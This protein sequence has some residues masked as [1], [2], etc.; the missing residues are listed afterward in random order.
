MD[1]RSVVSVVAPCKR[2][3]T[4]AYSLRVDDTWSCHHR[5]Y[6]RPWLRHAAGYVVVYLALSALLV[7]ALRLGVPRLET[8]GLFGAA[9]TWFLM[10]WSRS[11]TRRP[12]SVEES[13]PPASGDPLRMGR[14]RN[15]E[16]S[17]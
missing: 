8:G 1:T 2:G 5:P 16:R 12:S 9:W 15:P 11:K 17:S 10:T 6:E 7:L 13:R 3:G 14:H 4:C